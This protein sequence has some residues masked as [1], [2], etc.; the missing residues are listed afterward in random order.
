MALYQPRGSL[1]L[2]LL[3]DG[4]DMVLLCLLYVLLVFVNERGNCVVEGHMPTKA[5][6]KGPLVVLD[7]VKDRDRNRKTPEYNLLPVALWWHLGG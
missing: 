2:G 3:E 5:S 6:L 1:D 4:W 7:V